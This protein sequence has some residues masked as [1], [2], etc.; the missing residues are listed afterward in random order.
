MALVVICGCLVASGRA[1]VDPFIIRQVQERAAGGE[2][3][4]QYNLGLMHLVG[5]GVDQDAATGANWIRRAADQGHV[6]ATYTMG[7]LYLQGTGVTRDWV[8]AYAW[9]RVAETE[10]H[11]FAGTHRQRM[12]SRMTEEQVEEAVRRADERLRRVTARK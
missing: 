1:Q 5:E 8:E 11:D 2:A 9:M 4:A 12:E 3:Y 6:A 7:L 10:G